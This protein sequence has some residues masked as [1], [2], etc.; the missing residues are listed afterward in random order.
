M[1]P[2]DFRDALIALLEA[3]ADAVLVGGYAVAFHGHP[4]ATKDLDIL[5]RP[6]S[7]NALRVYAALVAFGAPLAAVGVGAG[8]FATPGRVVQIGLPPLRIDIVNQISGVTFDE[9]AAQ[10]PRLDVRGH[11]FRV[12]GLG[13]LLRNTRA[14]GRPQD[15]PAAAPRTNSRAV[16]TSATVLPGYTPDANCSEPSKGMV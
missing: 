16:C 2:D 10:A 5:V 9:A 15:R 14:A 1:L 11:P 6:S 3:E 12:I 7:E 13:A 8:D 4:R